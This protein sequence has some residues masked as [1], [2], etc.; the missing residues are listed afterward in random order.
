MIYV[1]SFVHLVY[2][3]AFLKATVR[4]SLSEPGGSCLEFMFL[5]LHHR[6]VGMF[7]HKMI[8]MMLMIMMMIIMAINLQHRHSQG[9]QV[10]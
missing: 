1:L 6:T 8:M 3:F 10:L 5:V 7:L 4:K 2:F 9:V